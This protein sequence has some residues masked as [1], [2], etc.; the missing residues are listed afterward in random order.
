MLTGLLPAAV[1]AALGALYAAARWR[2]LCARRGSPRVV[3]K[4]LLNGVA[5][6]CVGG[7]FGRL[8]SDTWLGVRM[9]TCFHVSSGRFIFFGH[10][11]TDAATVFVVVLGFVASTLA[12]VALHLRERAWSSAQAGAVLCAAMAGA[13]SLANE[14]L[15]LD[16]SIH[17]REPCNPDV[18]PIAVAGY[19][20]AAAGFL[21][22]RRLARP[23]RRR[24]AAAGLAVAALALLAQGSRSLALA[25]HTTIA[26]CGCE[27]S[28]GQLRGP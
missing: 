23:E 28:G 22:A 9:A 1:F 26:D 12:T 18:G 14:T 11:D 25:T 27:R 2:W 15:G 21:L 17:P 4:A 13:W 19:A 10:D 16:F 6:A 20:A 7:L 5:G 8:G 3:P 24:A